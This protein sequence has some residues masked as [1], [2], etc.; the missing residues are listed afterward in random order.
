MSRTLR[1]VFTGGGTGGHF[2]PAIAVC[3]ALREAAQK[4]GKNVSLYF[5][6]TEAY[7]PELLQSLG[8]RFVKIPSGKRRT[9]FSIQNYIDLFKIGTGCIIAFFHLL[10]LYPDVVFG[11]GGYASFPTLFAARLLRIPVI[12]HESDTVPGRVNLWA[13]TFASRIA[14]SFPDAVTRFPSGKA[15]VT[16]QPIRKTLLQKIDPAEAR[17][18]F[19]IDQAEQVPIIAVFGGSQGAQR[20]NDTILDLLPALLEEYVVIHQT[21]EALAKENADRAALVLQKSDNARRYHHYP[22]F[23]EEMLQKISSIT[24]VIISRSGSMIFEFAAWQI[25][26]LLIPLPEEISRD[27]TKNAFAYARAGCGT[28]LEEKNVTPHVFLATLKQLAT[29]QALRGQMTA[30][31]IAFAKL[32]ASDKMAHEILHVAEFHE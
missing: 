2:F 28:V 9:Y 5:F 17:R 21:G 23:S 30:A 6:S 27:Q 24:N 26:A 12:I 18:F 29:D 25:P 10:F 3:E 1:I 13:G 22:F 19:S 7:K 8:M 14:L 32:D 31:A 4:E 20:I 15:A 16:G 11:K